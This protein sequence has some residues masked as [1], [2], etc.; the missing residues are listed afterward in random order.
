MNDPVSNVQIE[1]VLASIRK[2]VSEEVRAQ[3]QPEEARKGPTAFGRKGEAS[4]E[5][6]APA[7]AEKLIL[8]PHLRVADPDPASDPERDAESAIGADRDADGDDLSDSFADAG[9]SFGREDHPDLFAEDEIE[10][11]PFAEISDEA[12]L[13]GFD[14]APVAFDGSS[15]MP[16]ETGAQRDDELAGDAADARALRARPEDDASEDD[17]FAGA[18]EDD[19]EEFDFEEMLA[20]LNADHARSTDFS[21]FGDGAAEAL[22]AA[23]H[24]DTTPADDLAD[25]PAEDDA[26]EDARFDDLDA[27]LSHLDFD[28]DPAPR[29]DR[30][31]LRDDIED[32]ELVEGQGDNVRSFESLF[33]RNETVTPK[34][35]PEPAEAEEAPEGYRFVAPDADDPTQDVDFLDDNSTGTQ[36]E[37]DFDAMPEHDALVG[38]AAHSRSEPADPYQDDAEDGDVTVDEE[39]LRELVSDILRQELQGALGERITRNVRKLVRREIQRALQSKDYI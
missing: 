7:A 35:E 21:D 20:S 13:R 33:R 28:A 6:E 1:D 3:T 30:S 11:A 38:R 25:T 29:H 18:A 15:W 10:E 14:D 37:A 12:A 24:V 4:R 26:A 8:A 39:A 27:V 17:A 5:E 22:A 34:S 32:A 36:P 31:E 16:A 19:G 23:P 9:L 2:L